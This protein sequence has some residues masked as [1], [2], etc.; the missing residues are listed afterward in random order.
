MGSTMYEAAPDLVYSALQRA[1]VA[2]GATFQGSDPRTRT[3]FFQRGRKNHSVGVQTGAEGSYLVGSSAGL[4]AFMS[5]ELAKTQQLPSPAGAPGTRA[6]TAE[7]ASE[8][9]RLGNLRERNLLTEDE[10]A[11]AKARAF[12][13]AGPPTA[14]SKPSEPPAESSPRPPTVSEREA[15]GEDIPAVSASA[16]TPIATPPAGTSRLGSWLETWHGLSRTKQIVIAVVVVLVALVA[17][18]ALVPS[19][20]DDE[21]STS[22]A[23]AVTAESGS[24]GGNEPTPA[25]GGVSPQVSAWAVDVANWSDQMGDAFSDLGTFLQDESF[26]N[27]LLLGD[28]DAVFEVAVPLAVMQQCSNSF[29]DPPGSS[30]QALGK[31]RVSILQACEEYERF[32]HPVLEGC[33]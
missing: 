2:S 16:T 29:P 31:S 12:E 18:G 3:V 27:R 9:E 20:G 4:D 7:L 14:P 22:P 10:F 26:N 28:Q 25:T 6:T 1:V 23:P 13:Q 8:L 33:R 19:E 30:A 5:V 24:G 21:P 11:A 17:I 15:S 32:G